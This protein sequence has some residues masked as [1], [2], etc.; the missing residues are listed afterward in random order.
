M[1]K[2][3]SKRKTKRKATGAARKSG[4]SRPLKVGDRVRVIDIP[5]GFKDLN[6]D[7]DQKNPELRTMRTGELFRFCVG[8]EFVI[9]E[10]NQYGYAELS[11][12]KDRTVRKKFGLNS[13][14]LEPEFLKRIQIK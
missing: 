11:V 6:Y 3:R 10:F 12:D 5:S 13:I 7:L 8:R 9:E 2:T 14:W 1:S 4:P